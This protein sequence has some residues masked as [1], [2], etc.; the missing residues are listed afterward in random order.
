MA[1]SELAVSVDIDGCLYC[2]GKR[3][4]QLFAIGRTIVR[5]LTVI[6]GSAMPAL[7]S[8]ST[9][10]E[11]NFDIRSV[12]QLSCFLCFSINY[13]IMTHYHLYDTLSPATR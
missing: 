1:S 3:S 8:H 11:L 4:V 10:T 5:Y 13:T 7:L 2:M 12:S 6:S 9:S